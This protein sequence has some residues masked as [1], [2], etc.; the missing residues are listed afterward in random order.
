[1]KLD[2]AGLGD[3]GEVRVLRQQSISGMD[4]VYVCDFSRADHR[5]NV[6]IALRQLR[7]TNADGFVGKLD[8]QRVPVSLAV[9]RNSADAQLFAGANHAQ[10]NL[11]AVRNKDFIEHVLNEC[12]ADTLV[13]WVLTLAATV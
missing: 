12:R 11:A 5:W 8:V 10:G 9:N 7:R 1:M 3:F 13:R 6:E 2:V 4:G